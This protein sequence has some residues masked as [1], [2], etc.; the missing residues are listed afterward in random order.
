MTLKSLAI[1]SHKGGVGKTSIAVNLAAH[2]A[3]A[4]KKVCLLDSDFH[5]PSILTFFKPQV[6]WLNAYLLGEEPIENCLQDFA[7]SLSLPGKLF[8]GFADPTADSIQQ[9]IRIDQKT[10][11]KMLQNFI[12]LKKQ[13]KRKPYDLEYLI[14]D[15]SPGTGYSTVNVMLTTDSSLFIVRLNN[16]DIMG[17]S[18]MIAGLFK[19]LKSRSLV[20][21]N[22][23]PAKMIRAQKTKSEIQKLIESRFQQDI[24][25]KVVEFL[26]WI[27][28]DLQLQNIEF[29]GALRTLRGEDSSRMIFTLEQPQHI[30][31]TTLIELIPTLFG[32]Q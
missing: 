27:P 9:V 17:T 14:M 20:L 22:Q 7:P 13:L 5:G 26:G 1:L 25:D 29:E 2:L 10:S 16:A 32:E 8:I 19:Q 31:S 11:M 30:F 24:G 23:I 12:R 18:Q 4:G 28:T 21:A 15:C 3:K 6:H